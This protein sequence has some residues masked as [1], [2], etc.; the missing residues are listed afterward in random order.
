MIS[1]RVQ[2][3]AREAVIAACFKG[4]PVPAN[5]YRRDSRSHIWWD[6]GVRKAESAVADLMRVGS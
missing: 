6:M 4:G 2:R 3:E 5:P 1:I